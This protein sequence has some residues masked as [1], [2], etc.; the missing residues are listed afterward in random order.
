MPLEFQECVVKHEGKGKKIV[1]PVLQDMLSDVAALINTA[2]AKPNALNMR[3]WFGR[4]NLPS[5]T[6]DKSE[7]TIVDRTKAL[8]AWL[9]SHQPICFTTKD[10]PGTL[11]FADQSNDTPEFFLGHGFPQCRWSWGERVCTLIHEFT[12]KAIATQDVQ[13]GVSS[14]MDGLV[15]VMSY[16]MACLTLADEPNLFAKALVN[17]ENWGYYLCSYRM[18][19]G[20]CK[21]L[22]D[23][24][25]H[26]LHKPHW[27]GGR[28][29]YLSD[30]PG[31]KDDPLFFDLSYA[32]KRG[33]NN[34]VL[35]PPPSGPQEKLLCECG[36]EFALPSEHVTHLRSCEV[37]KGRTQFSVPAGRSQAE[38]LRLAAIAARRLD[39]LEAD[40]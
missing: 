25:W 14:G 37:A 1:Q 31:H 16:G 13:L 18:E 38:Q 30:A 15:P 2:L 4:K 21:G 35:M 24:R 7:A 12:H 20:V 40:D 26:W 28:T 36:N 11:A 10:A 5:G 27:I 19:A 32:K 22:D 17:A 29:P 23:P 39:A 9:A 33:D 8:A 3:L 34:S 6:S